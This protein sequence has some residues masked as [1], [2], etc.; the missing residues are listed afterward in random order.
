MRYLFPVLIVVFVIASVLIFF[1]GDSGMTAYRSL[2]RYREKLTA[3]VDDLRRRNA[4]LTADLSSL[5]TN[6]ERTLVQARGIG[7]YQSG[8]QVVRLEGLPS[9]VEPTAIGNLLKLRKTN[10][11]RNSVFKS[12]AMGVSVILLAYAGISIRRSRRKAHDTQ[13]G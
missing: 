11:A 6:P 3:N 4:D 8:D 13:R 10:D 5:R 1:F 9:R 2:D 12:T 7:L